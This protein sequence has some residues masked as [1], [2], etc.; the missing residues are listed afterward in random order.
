MA[1]GLGFR[2]QQAAQL[3]VQSKHVVWNRPRVHLQ[4]NP[5]ERSFMIVPI[6]SRVSVVFASPGLTDFLTLS[7]WYSCTS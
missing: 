5:V 6:F 3:V 2:R 4:L 7:S 1:D